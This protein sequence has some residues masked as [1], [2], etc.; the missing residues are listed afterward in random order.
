[1]KN[2]R[3]F[4]TNTNSLSDFHI[5][6]NINRISYP[7]SD[8]SLNLLIFQSPNK[9]SSSNNRNSMT[10]P[11]PGAIF[12]SSVQLLA[13][14]SLTLRRTQCHAHPR[15]KARK[16]ITETRSTYKSRKIAREHTRLTRT[17]PWRLLTRRGNLSIRVRSDIRSTSYSRRATR[18]ACV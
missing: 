16:N 15:R 14:A 11:T 2:W 18:L 10:F 3:Q 8:S 12:C 17:I 13:P 4:V 7:F 1:M 5:P 9:N 6:A